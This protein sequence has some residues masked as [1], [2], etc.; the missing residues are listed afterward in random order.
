VP[1]SLQVTMPAAT[2]STTSMTAVSEATSLYT[3]AKS[4]KIFAEALTVRLRWRC[5]L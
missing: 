5:V 1:L 4:E 2:A 3:F